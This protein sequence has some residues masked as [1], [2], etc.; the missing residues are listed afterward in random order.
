MQARSIL[1]SCSSAFLLSGSLVLGGYGFLSGQAEVYRARDTARLASLLAEAK[2]NSHAGQLHEAAPGERVLKTGSL[3][4]ELLIP[5]LGVDTIV[6]E[7]DRSGVLR[8][9]A[10]HIPGTAMPYYPGGNVGIAGHRD[11]V[12]RP[13]RFIRAGDLIV[14][15]TP[16]GRYRYRV[17]SAHVVGSGD[18][19][20]LGNTGRSILTLVTCY[21]FYFVGPAPYRFIVQATEMPPEQAGADS[22]LSLG[23]GA[24]GKGGEQNSS[25]GASR[26]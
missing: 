23:S 11:T 21:P 26:R 1:R 4:G 25:L 15:R 19:A 17:R 24:T 7:G 6:L 10:G 20:V 13:L 5:R 2:P 12:F 16:A 18:I 14:L 3:L 9:G 8:R 22:S